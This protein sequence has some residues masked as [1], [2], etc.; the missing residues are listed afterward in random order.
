MK[1][2][3]KIFVK[4]V[5]FFF[6]G[7]V[8]LIA[9]VFAATRPIFPRADI[10][11]SVPFSLDDPPRDLIP[12]GETLAHPKPDSPQGHPG[13]DFQWDHPADVLASHDGIATEIKK[14]EEDKVFWE[15]TLT[16]G[17]YS[18]IYKELGDYSEN[19][20]L[21]SEVKKGEL[22]GHPY[23]P[24]TPEGNASHY[25]LHW[26]FGY[27]FRDR[28][29]PMTYFDDAS[30]ASIEEIWNESTNQFKKDFPYIC[31]GDYFGKEK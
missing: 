12:M 21:F 29:C 11:I 25:Q 23:N 1:K 19:I 14:V 15:I 24:S 27:M 13:I 22:I 28:L 10:E 6:I 20:K 4:V 16:K 2:L 7:L 9:L 18:T 31:S 5:L 3:L 26:E 8:S 17:F 30:L